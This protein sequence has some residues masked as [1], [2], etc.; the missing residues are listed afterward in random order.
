[1][2]NF[3]PRFRLS[4]FLILAGAVAVA[5]FG[6]ERTLFGADDL[7][8]VEDAGAAALVLE[9]RSIAS[10]CAKERPT[11]LPPADLSALNELFSISPP[12][13]D[14]AERIQKLLDPHCLIAVTINAESRVKAIR[15][16]APARLQQARGYST[17]IKVVNEA[18]IR[19]P[20]KVNI[21]AASPGRQT[22]WLKAVVSPLP[23]IG[24]GVSRSARER[25]SGNKV[26]YMIL[27]LRADEAGKR[28]AT[29][30]FDAGQG[31]QDL[32][33]RAEVPVLFT[34]DP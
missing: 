6:R 26:Q 32:G 9:G 1:M 20:L 15:G 34:V 2:K 11:L 7:P 28:E 33:F 18:G 8:L 13:Q 17:L 22:T 14:L 3:L 31:T 16:P 24:A 4:G 27:F 30:K 10:L 23:R 5:C 21:A 25:L 12:P 29:L 19:Q